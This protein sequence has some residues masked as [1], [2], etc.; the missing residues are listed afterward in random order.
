MIRAVIFDMFETLI[1]HYQSP[2]YFGAQMAEDAGIAENKFQELWRPTESDRSIG[3]QT[4]EEVLEMI[5]RANEC[6]SGEVINKIVQ[7]R[8]ATKEDCFRH[9]HPEI[10]PMLE[11]LKEKGWKVGLIN[12]CFSEEADVIRKS[13][14][15][16]YFDA[17]Y[18]SYE[19]GVQKPDEEIY[20]RCMERLEVTPEECLYIGDGGSNE[21]E[22]ATAIGMKAVQA[23]WY[24]Q[25]GTLQPTGRK[26]EFV[27]MEKP[28]DVLAYLMEVRD[29][30]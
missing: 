2:L 26:D 28:M 19:Q 16:P 20:R 6:Y 1:T 10:L 7:K 17:V 29:R 15:F 24:L 9:L 25:N 4:L 27:Q 12:N 8:I 3:K 5:L 11:Q 14:L 21:L 23:A 13:I 30:T 18:L 22:A